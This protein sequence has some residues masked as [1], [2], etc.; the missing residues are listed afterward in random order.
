MKEK[1]IRDRINAFLRNKLQHLVVPASMGLGLALGACDT[2]GLKSNQDSSPDSTAIQPRSGG[3]GGG[4]TGAGGSLY[5]LGG[6]IPPG[7]GGSAGSGGGLGGAGGA[8]YGL[9]GSAP[10]SGGAGGGL[11]GAAGTMYGLGGRSGG[12]GG[13]LG[14][15]AGTMY[16][17]GGRSGGAGGGLGGAGGTVYGTGGFKDAGGGDSVDSG[18]IPET[19][20]SDVGQSPDELISEAGVAD[21]KDTSPR[22]V[23]SE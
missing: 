4:L 3:A 10:R 18:A 5:G 8:L 17:L 14:G 19:G 11:G 1:D 23:F 22:D 16:G 15:A 12:A 7:S 6:S 20:K 13:G 9:G 21:A 2:S